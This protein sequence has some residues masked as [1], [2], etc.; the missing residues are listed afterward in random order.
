MWPVHGDVCQVLKKL[1]TTVGSDLR[2]KKVR[3]LLNKGCSEVT[4]L[5]R[6]VRKHSTQETDVGSYTADTELCQ[7]AVGA[8][9]G[10]FERAPAGG[11]LNQHGVKVG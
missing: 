6:R 1:R 5:E 2:F 4:G 7:R 3:T 10:L 8:R 9:R 11:A